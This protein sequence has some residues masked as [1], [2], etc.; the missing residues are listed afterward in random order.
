MPVRIAIQLIVAAITFVSLVGVAR[1]SFEDQPR[2]IFSGNDAETRQLGRFF[3]DFGSDDN[4]LLVVMRADL[5]ERDQVR[6]VRRL[7]E[8]LRGVEGIDDVMSIFDLRREDAVLEPLLPGDEDPEEFF[9]DAVKEA[10]R[11]PMAAGQFLSRDGRVS[12]VVVHV[13]EGLHTISGLAPVVQAVRQVVTEVAASSDLHPL[14]GG[15]P[16]VLV[17]SLAA[18]RRDQL[19]FGICSGVVTVAIAMVLFRCW[20]SLVVALIPPGLG[21]LWTVG[22]MGWLGW[23]INGINSALPTVV[24]IIGFANGVHLLLEFRRQR[25]VLEDRFKALRQALATVAPA[26]VMTALTSAIGFASLAAA[27]T[28]SVQVFG[29]SCAMGVLLALLAVLACMPVM[30]TYR[31]AD[32]LGSFQ[33]NRI[34][35]LVS[36]VLMRL[37]SVVLRNRRLIVIASFGL[38]VILLL[39]ASRLRPDLRTTEAMSDASETARAMQLCDEGFGGSLGAYVVMQWPKGQTLEDR[40]VLVVA[41]HVHELLAKCEDLHEPMSILNVLQGLPRRSQPLERRVRHLSRFPEER[42]Q[43]LVRTDLRR[44]TIRARLPNTG[45]AAW[46]ENLQ[47]LRQ[48]LGELEQQHPGFSFELTGSAVIVGH[49]MRRMIGDLARS[50]G[51]AAL[52]IIP[53]IAIVFRSL[54]WGMISILP[55][56][57]PLLLNAAALWI[58]GEPLRI[59]AVIT[60]SICLGVAVDDTIH[61]MARVRHYRRQGVPIQDSITQAMEHVGVALVISTLVLIGGFSV[62]LCSEVPPIRW[63][64]GLCCTAF[65]SALVADLTMLPALMALGSRREDGTS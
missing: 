58:L 53:L 37:L 22:A 4:R 2:T 8:Q 7:V 54:G 16:A 26:C 62:M 39:M 18:V 11:H 9:A 63:F 23:P 15:N 21:A 30:C 5:T 45:A 17:D 56:A 64:S 38:S 33:R 19:R 51:M 60:F 6:T 55:N 13:G 50:L 12:L 35:S 61:F 47:R 43:A 36:S 25:T 32:R 41:G 42:L 14:V 52:I 44:M 3:D 10:L 40:H 24:F 27:R 48:Q 57:T 34:E 49:N 20:T 31:F 28:P 65:A 46:D 29:I 59:T 1:V